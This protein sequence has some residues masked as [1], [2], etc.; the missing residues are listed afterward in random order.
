M[1]GH[2]DL[3]EALVIISAQVHYNTR[4]LHFLVSHNKVEIPQEIVN[5]ANK[6]ERKTKALQ[7][8]L[9]AQAQPADNNKP[10]EP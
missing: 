2:R 3:M 7:A 4:L 1:Y 10:E 5:A 9:D 6:L 8:A